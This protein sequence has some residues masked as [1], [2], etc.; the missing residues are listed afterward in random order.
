VFCNGI[1]WPYT[2]YMEE[3]DEKKKVMEL[4][5]GQ[6]VFFDLRL[7]HHATDNK[8]D[9]D[10]I[11]FCVR[12]THQ[13][14]KYFSFNNKDEKSGI[15]NVFEEGPDFYLKEE[16]SSDNQKYPMVRKIGEM[17]NIYSTIDHSKIEAALE[18]IGAPVV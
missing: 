7:I 3:F 4:K 2:P 15:V 1:D 16:W 8:T 5:A 18:A 6:I 11:C 13:K 9:E 17:H 12:L 10:R 14:T